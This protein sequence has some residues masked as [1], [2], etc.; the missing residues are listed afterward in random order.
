MSARRNVKRCSTAALRPGMCR[1]DSGGRSA[2]SPAVAAMPPQEQV[3]TSAPAQSA[4][5]RS[6]DSP[7]SAPSMGVTALRS[8]PSRSSADNAVVLAPSTRVLHMWLEE[9]CNADIA[10][11][12]KPDGARIQQNCRGVAGLHLR[13]T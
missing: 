4:I 5:P 3:P 7:G 12:D 6:V 13:W 1:G 8:R 2:R 11:V 10:Y 9:S